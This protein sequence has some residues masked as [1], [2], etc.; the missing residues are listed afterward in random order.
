VQAFVSGITVDCIDPD[1]VADFWA[2][3]LGLTDQ[4]PLPGW[5]QLG[6]TDRCPRLTFQ[7]VPEPP[8]GKTRLHLDVTVG[9]IDAGVGR[10]IEL[11]GSDTGERHDYDEGVVRVMAD[12]EGHEFCLVQYDA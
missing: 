8:V 4:D 12:P 10:V 5:R 9:D 1:R 11:G 6:A 2:S 3:L 7:P